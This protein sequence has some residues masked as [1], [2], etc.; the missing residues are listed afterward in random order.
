[1]IDADASVTDLPLNVEHYLISEVAHGPTTRKLSVISSLSQQTWGKLGWSSERSPQDGAEP[2][3]NFVS[4]MM[5]K[6]QKRGSQE[7]AAD[8]PV[9]KTSSNN[10]ALFEE[11]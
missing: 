8:Q 2:K 1:M 7:S 4:S 3:T 11:T 10:C 9:T 5:Q 6:F